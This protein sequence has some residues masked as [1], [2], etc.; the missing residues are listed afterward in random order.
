VV[1]RLLHH[2]QVAQVVEVLTMLIQVLAEHQDK[3]IQAA[4]VLMREQAAAEAVQVVLA[5]TQQQRRL[6]LEV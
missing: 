5:E 2:N 1:I 3:V 6:V 4:Q